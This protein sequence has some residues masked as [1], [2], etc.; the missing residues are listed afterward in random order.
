MGTTEDKL[1]KLIETKGLL[2]QKLTEKGIDV[3]NEDNFYTLANTVGDIQSRKKVKVKF[4]YSN[5]NGAKELCYTDALPPTPSVVKKNVYDTEP[6]EV[7]IL[8][9]SIVIIAGVSTTQIISGNYI[10]L[11]FSFAFG[12]LAFYCEEDT[13]IE[14]S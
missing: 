8:K 11:S 2:K 7:E 14:Y 13:T 6:I 1:A 12:F 3:S 9:G 10:P 5:Y 4:V